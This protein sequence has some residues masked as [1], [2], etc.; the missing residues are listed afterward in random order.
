ME[1]AAAPVTP[2]AKCSN[3]SHNGVLKSQQAAE[4]ALLQL[5][6]F[7]PKLRETA[8]PLKQ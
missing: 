7:L 1:T 5:E 4:E 8:Y 3:S 6:A 2:P